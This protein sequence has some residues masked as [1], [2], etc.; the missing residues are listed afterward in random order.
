MKIPARKKKNWKEVAGADEEKRKK[1]KQDTSDDKND[2]V[3]EAVEDDGNIADILKQ[4][5]VTSKRIIT[6]IGYCTIP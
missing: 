5:N 3:Q 6:F 4:I 2:N 1:A